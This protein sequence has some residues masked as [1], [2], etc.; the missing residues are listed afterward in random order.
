MNS[1]VRPDE[2]DSPLQIRELISATQNY[3]SGNFIPRHQARAGCGH[4]K[5]Q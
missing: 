5:Q 1:E 4:A 2:K 3:Y